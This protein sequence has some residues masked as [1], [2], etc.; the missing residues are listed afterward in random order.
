M[1]D[2]FF[3]TF[4]VQEEQFS[5]VILLLKLLIVSF[6]SYLVVILLIPRIKWRLP[7]SLCGKD[8]CKKGTPAGDIPM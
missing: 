3:G 4:H 2:K 8:L 5:I 6:M 7:S 1:K